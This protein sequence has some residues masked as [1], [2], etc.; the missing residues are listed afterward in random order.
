MKTGF[1]VVFLAC[2]LLTPVGNGS[3]L[4][5]AQTSQQSTPDVFVGI[6]VAYG[7]ISEIKSLIDEVSAYTNL[8]VIGCTGVTYNQTLLN[9]ICQQL[10]E[11]N[12]SFIVYRDWLRRNS[13]EWFPIWV[14]N[15]KTLWGD[16]FL[17][18]YY[19][20]EL[21]GKQ[22]D[23]HEHLTVTNAV[24]AHDAAEQFTEVVGSQLR[25]FNL[26]H[27]SSTPI[28][29]FTSDYALY[30]FD[31]KAGYDA[32]FAEFGWNYSRQLNV[33][34]CRGAANLQGKEWGVMI[35]WTYTNPPYIESGEKLYE[36]M[37]L[38]Y[39]NGA[40]YIVIFDTNEEYTAGILKE[41]HL[42]AIKQFWQY[43]QEKPRNNTINDRIALALPKDYAYGFRG[44]ND[45]IWGLWEANQ[46]SLEL[47]VHID[48]LLKQYG[49]KLDIIYEDGLQGCSSY[50][51]SKIIYWS[52][53]GLPLYPYPSSTTSQ[54]A[55]VTPSPT[56]TQQP[57]ASST[58]VATTVASLGKYG[59]LMATT[60]VVG[61]TT[62][63]LAF[64]R[65][66]TRKR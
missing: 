26:T 8:L 15:A 66:K 35:T 12:M 49:T 34:L 5:E 42:Q 54:E 29:L 10:H 43:T 20:D 37:V 46:F 56:Q 7:N 1:I 18:F 52:E 25:R 64:F 33:A 24:D 45:K 48:Y 16:K 22:L 51:Y 65:R 60:V 6:D 21:G 59:A 2:V 32:V 53:L 39:E 40:K 62:L 47:S 30:W 57:T 9:E 23:R 19:S 28:P 36:D 13:T 61:V 63:A 17:G 27:N 41:E 3:S 44:P 55:D 4:A 14:E 50:G 31:Y 11:K 38:A 58:Q